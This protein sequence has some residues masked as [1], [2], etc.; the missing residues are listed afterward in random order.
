[1][2]RIMNTGA[3]LFGLDLALEVARD[4]IELGNHAFDL[5]DPAALFVDLKFFQADERFS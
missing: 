1:M 2:A 5:S 3:I 4:A